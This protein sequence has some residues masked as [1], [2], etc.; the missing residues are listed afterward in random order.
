MVLL[1]LLAVVVVVQVLEFV[2]VLVLII[3]LGLRPTGGGPA[4]GVKLI[5][6]SKARDGG[7]VDPIVLMWTVALMWMEE[8]LQVGL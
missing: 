8:D 6:D 7:I 1:L 4:G 2:P 5:L 3:V